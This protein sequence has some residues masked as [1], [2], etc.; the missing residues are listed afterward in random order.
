MNTRINITDPQKVIIDMI[1]K[2]YPLQ[3]FIIREKSLLF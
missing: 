3:N 1:E 2:Y